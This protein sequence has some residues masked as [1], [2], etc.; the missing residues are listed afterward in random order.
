METY[1]F[2][3]LLLVILVVVIFAISKSLDLRKEAFPYKVKKSILSSAELNFYN[4]LKYHTNEFD[5]IILAKV[6][7]ADIVS[8]KKIKDRIKYWNKIQAKHIDFIICT[9]DSTPIVGIE[10]DDRS[11]KLKSAYQNDTFKNKLFEEIGI[12]LFRIPCSS[13]YDFLAIK[14]HLTNYS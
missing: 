4:Q 8:V 12:S 10:L 3:L 7:L 13:N 6:R 14:K 2:Y 9:I 1:Y 5:V 11:H